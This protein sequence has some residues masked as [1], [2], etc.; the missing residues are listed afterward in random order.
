[1]KSQLGNLIPLDSTGR[2]NESE[3]FSIGIVTLV[4]GHIQSDMNL[5]VLH[6]IPLSIGRLRATRWIASQALNE[7]L[8]IT[9]SCVK[10]LKQ[11][12][13]KSSDRYLLTDSRAQ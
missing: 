9:N 4:Q 10:K 3:F 13:Q 7:Q 6:G 8:I 11:L 2:K 12:Q 5:R 1:M